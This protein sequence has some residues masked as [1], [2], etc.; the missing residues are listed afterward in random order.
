MISSI[1]L[2][3]SRHFLLRNQSNYNVGTVYIFSNFERLTFNVLGQRANFVGVSRRLF[4]ICNMG[5]N[6]HLFF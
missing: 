6:N 4:L 1:P 2:K 3:L 5:N